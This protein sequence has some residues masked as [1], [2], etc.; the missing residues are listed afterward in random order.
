MN[1]TTQNVVIGALAVAVGAL[2]WKVLKKPAPAKSKL[3]LVYVGSGWKWPRPDRFPTEKSFGE[4]LSTLGYGAAVF[5]PGW[6]V[7][8]TETMNTVMAFQTDYNAIREAML[9]SGADIGPVIVIDG[10]IGADTV[11]ALI[12]ALDWQKNNP[13]DS[14]IALTTDAKNQ[15]KA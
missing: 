7:T 4:A 5:L 3:K 6:E 10:L 2:A 14:W 8:S 12:F 1:N 15:L 11:R 13:D 9:Q